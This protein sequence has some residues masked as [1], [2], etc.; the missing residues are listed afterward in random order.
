LLDGKDDS[1]KRFVSRCGDEFL[2]RKEYGGEITLVFGASRTDHGTTSS[3]N[4]EGRISGTIPGGI[5]GHLSSN[6]D[7]KNT[8]VG[9]EQISNFI[10]DET[11]R[12]LKSTV[13]CAIPRSGETSQVVHDHPFIPKN[14]VELD[15]FLYC[16][17]RWIDAVPISFNY[18]DYANVFP[19]SLDQSVIDAYQADYLA[20]KKIWSDK[21]AAEE[22]AAQQKIA[23]EQQ[24]LDA[25][26]PSRQ[27]PEKV[28]LEVP[29]LKTVSPVPIT[30]LNGTTRAGRQARLDATRKFI[31][32][33]MVFATPSQCAIAGCDGY[34]EVS[35]AC[36]RCQD[37]VQSVYQIYGG[38]NFCR[39]NTEC[40][41]AVSCQAASDGKTGIC[42]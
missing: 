9:L 37:S 42:R 19:L 3:T 40:T 5:T 15:E 18:T 27:V 36:T 28:V 30:K 16:L 10:V 20:S 31:R 13:A 26:K 24:E 4:G 23:K 25:A 2:S 34:N 33:N 6:V 22:K 17:P 41:E 7:F 35:G 11:A 38:M 8:L 1:F 29:K 12:D 14:I 32:E 39:D 21:L